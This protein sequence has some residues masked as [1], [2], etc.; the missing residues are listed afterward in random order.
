MIGVAFAP[1][2]AAGPVVEAG[3]IR[4]FTASQVRRVDGP[5]P[6][7][8]AFLVVVNPQGALSSLAGQVVAQGGKVLLLG[9]LDTAAAALAGVVAEPLPA[10]TAAWAACASAPTY[11]TTASDGLI[12]YADHPLAGAS[13]FQERP[14]LRFDF[15]E[16]W[17]NLGYGRIEGSGQWGLAQGARC[18]GASLIAA[19][20]VEGEDR[21]PFITLH[22][23]PAGGSVLWI[24]RAVGLVDSLEWALVEAFFSDYRPDD[25][26]CLPHLREAPYGVGAVVSM[27]LDCDEDI[28]SARP[29]FELYRS[30][31]VPFSLAVKTAQPAV[32]EDFAL[33][34]E[35]AAA[36]GAVLS[37]SV[38]HY[39]RWGDDPGIALQE[40]VDSRAWLQEHLPH[41]PIRHMVSP[42]HQTPVFVPPLLVQAG[43]EGFIG[44]VVSAEPDYILARG[45]IVP[46]AAFP[47]VSHAQQCMVHGDCLLAEGDPLAVYKR[48]FD[49]ALA[50]SAIFGFLDHPFS[51]RYS[52]G[53][54]D[55]AQR[56][57]AHAA[58]LDYIQASAQPVGGVWFVNE[59]QCLDLVRRRMAC[60]LNVEEGQVRLTDP[61]AGDGPPL[62]VRWRG[63]TLSATEL[64]A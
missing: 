7:G 62:A 2:D 27:R 4:S 55:E 6:E 61:L 9:T 59:D 36:G 21:L 38:N 56:L 54:L 34:R 30:R 35:V 17:N 32:E 26:P 63:R 1:G 13:P 52:Y 22:D 11:G 60:A 37:H 16:E 45:G 33:L 42:F 19:V 58:F 50:T 41:I 53:W 8:M 20:N 18:D 39:V 46:G 5:A 23:Q 49:A 31:G 47:F 40:A 29:L 14:L 43:Y 12:R 51:P 64:G 25:R 3:L 48:A 15:T 24:N 10:D 28:K 57:Q 44:G